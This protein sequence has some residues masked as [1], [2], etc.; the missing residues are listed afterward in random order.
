MTNNPYEV[1]PAGSIEVTKLAAS[2]RKGRRLSYS[3]LPSVKVTR[4]W[5]SFYAP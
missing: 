3:A 4:Q 2:V 5:S 1:E